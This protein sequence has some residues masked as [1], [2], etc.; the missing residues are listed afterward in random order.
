MLRRLVTLL[1]A[2][3][4][5][6]AIASLLLWPRTHFISDRIQRCFVFD[7]PT[8]SQGTVLGVWTDKGVVCF[9]SW[10]FGVIYRTPSSAPSTGDRTRNVLL[11]Q[12]QLLAME[13]NIDVIAMLRQAAQTDP[14]YRTSKPPNF[15]PPRPSFFRR[16]GFYTILHASRQPDVWSSELDVG[17]PVWFLTFLFSFLPALWLRRHL[18][19]RRQLRQGLCPTCSYDLRASKERC[20]ECGSPIPTTNTEPLPTNN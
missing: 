4:L 8:R 6:L 15:L 2:A 18:R 13:D 10:R 20:P 16:L 19:H 17:C 9:R 11:Q 7:D 5:V 1:A 12:Q 14:I 3:S